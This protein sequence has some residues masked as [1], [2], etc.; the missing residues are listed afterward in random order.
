MS[1]TDREGPLHETTLH[2]RRVGFEHLGQWISRG[3]HDMV[4]T[5]WP[6][7]L[8]GLVVFVLSLLTLRTAL[9]D[10]FLLPGVATAF[11]LVGPILATGLYAISRRL[12]A[13]HAGTL[14][15]ALCAWRTVSRR[16]WR[17]GL[18]LVL[19]GALWVG[20]STLLFH[21][22]VNV[23][24]HDLN[25]LVR[26][27]LTQKTEHFILWTLAGGL[28]A[29][30][31]FAMTVIAVPLLLDRDVTTRTAILAS[32]RAVGENPVPMTFWAGF[33]GLATALSMATAMAGF[34]LLYPLMG[35]A[36]WHLYRDLV[37]VDSASVAQH[38]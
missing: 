16:L 9:T 17:L 1:T 18:L 6:S 30:L 12:E 2:I 27:V 32:I 35:H 23:E 14:H 20:I 5:G 24:I 26:Y 4:R 21:L 19:I 22:F 10:P 37:E 28:L 15:D 29:A 34:I 36:S 31:V 7:Y 33:I 38:S 11:V 25:D 13:G 3:W 8:H